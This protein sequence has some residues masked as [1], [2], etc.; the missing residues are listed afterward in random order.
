MGVIYRKLDS[1]RPKYLYP[2]GFRIGKV[3]FGSWKICAHHKRIAIVEGPL[4]AI[5]AWEARIPAVAL[6]G[7]RLSPDQAKLIRS[8]GIRSVVTMTDN[9]QAGYEAVISVKDGLPGINV[10]VGWY[11]HTWKSKDPGELKAQRRRTMFLSPRK[12]HEWLAD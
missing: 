4:D 2:R 12:Y 1:G 10:E 3:L 8:L 11:R 9:D 6:L 5:A 7:A